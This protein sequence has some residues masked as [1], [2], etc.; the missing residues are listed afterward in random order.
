MPLATRGPTPLPWHRTACTLLVHV[1][2]RCCCR[3]T[4]LF[5]I[6]TF[7]FCADGSHGRFHF[8]THLQN[9]EPVLFIMRVN[10]VFPYRFMCISL[11]LIYLI[12]QLHCCCW[13]TPFPPPTR[14]TL[15][16]IFSPT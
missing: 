16:M 10:D 4:L 9:A 11:Q 12:R 13:A 1:A 2:Q 5:L 3:F 15:H 6:P 14:P 8:P 7:I